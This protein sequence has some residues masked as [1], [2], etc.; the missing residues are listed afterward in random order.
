MVRIYIGMNCA[1]QPIRATDHLV[2]TRRSLLSR[3]KNWDDQESWNDFFTTYWKLIFMSA[4]KAGCTEA[5]CQ[6]VVQETVISVAK[7]IPDFKYDSNMG[8]FKGWLLQLTRWRIRDQLRKRLPV[9]VTETD[10]G[11]LDQ[12]D[13]MEQVP[14]PAGFVPEQEWEADWEKNL[15]DAAVERVKR[16]IDPKLFQI[17]DLYTLQEWPAEKVRTLLHVGAATVYM[18]KIRVLNLIKKEMRRL[19]K[20]MVKE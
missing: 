11:W 17:F 18:A 7:R 5:E 8:S 12:A 19:E 1:S 9:E 3:L 16:K 2:P 13:L 14:D 4:R 6:D 20:E 10:S 15:F